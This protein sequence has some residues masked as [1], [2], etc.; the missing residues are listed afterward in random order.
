MDRM[1]GKAQAAIEYLT[2]YVWAIL[3]I[4]LVIIVL[5]Q[6]GLF[7][8]NIGPRASPGSCFITRPYGPGTTLGI[9]LTGE[10][11]GDIPEFVGTF[12][13][14]G[15]FF[16]INKNIT[17]TGNTFTITGWEY[18]TS[19]STGFKRVDMLSV[20][21]EALCGLGLGVWLSNSGLGPS[22]NGPIDSATMFV[23][24]KNQHSA[25]PYEARVY[26][27]ANSI[28]LN[29]WYFLVGVYNGIGFSIYING[30][31]ANTTPAV[32]GTDPTNSIYLC[33]SYSSLGSSSYTLEDYWPGYLSDVQLYNVSL[34]ATDIASLY[35]EGINGAPI[36]IQ[37]LVGWWPLNG[38][39]NDY[40]GDGYDGGPTNITFNEQ[41]VYTTNYQT[42]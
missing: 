23:D 14:H 28:S 25:L 36:Q 22:G 30:Q 13:G 27:A 26:S 10:C 29:K 41:W 31:L 11:T 2:T 20:K 17:V 9:S 3:A 4:A 6:L 21:G 42:P 7:G 32:S 18:L 15:S 40:S 5:Y 1:Y 38:N 34:S 35:P 8:G 19:L 24:E 37:N 16:D 39:A 12:V 33:T